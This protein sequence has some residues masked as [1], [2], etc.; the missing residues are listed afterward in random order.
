M[1]TSIKAYR[2]VIWITTCLLAVDL[3]LVVIH[4]LKLLNICFDR[5]FFSIEEDRGLAELIQYT[6]ELAIVVLLILSAIRHK[7]KAL[8]AWVVLFVY[9]VA[10]DAFS[11]H[12][13]V[14]EYLSDS[15]E[16][17][18]SFFRPQDIGELIVSGSTG[19]ILFSIIGLCYAR[20]SSAFRSITHDIILL[21]SGLVFFGVFV[22]SIHGAINAFTGE[23][24]LIEDGGELVV[25]SLILAYVWAVFSVPMEK[26]V[27]VVDRIWSSVRARFF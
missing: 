15:G 14:G 4:C 2:S 24:G 21:F 5:P 3:A 25:I 13:N 10:D 17:A 6:Q 18:P 7:I 19:L 16:F 22:D 12:E 11:I 23:L 27:R 26:Q 8:Y 1:N 9:V 20:G